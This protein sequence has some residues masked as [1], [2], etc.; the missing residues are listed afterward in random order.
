MAVDN[1]GGA[2]LARSVDA[3]R[4]LGLT[5]LMGN[6]LGLESVLRVR[7]V[8][9]PQKRIAGTL[10]GGVAD[11]EWGIEEVRAGRIRPTLDRTFTLDEAEAAHTRLAAGDAV[12]NIVFAVS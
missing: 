6:V 10:M 4:P 8:F 11:L 2:S 1:L 9:F 7:D 12:G 5:V 3:T